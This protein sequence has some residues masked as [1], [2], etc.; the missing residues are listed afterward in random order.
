VHV[1]TSKTD[2]K[3]VPANSEPVSS[4]AV[5]SLGGPFTENN[6]VGEDI[7]AAGETATAVIPSRFDQVHQAEG[8]SHARAG[9]TDGGLTGRKPKVWRWVLLLGLLALIAL[10]AL[11]RGPSGDASSEANSS[12]ASSSKD[13][14]AK[15]QIIVEDR[16]SSVRLSTQW[17]RVNISTDPSRPMISVSSRQPFRMRVNGE[18]YF[19]AAQTPRLIRF[20]GASFMELK[21]LNGSADVKITR[22]AM[23][24]GG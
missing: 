16:V 12:V 23:K 9:D 24:E 7:I 6:S 15:P 2:S 3:A 20:G 19:I 1:L 4:D 18:L 17:Q 14:V 10:V 11:K 22:S 8:S 13:P 5:V 21:T